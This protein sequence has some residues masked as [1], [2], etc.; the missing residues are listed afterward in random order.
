[1]TEIASVHRRFCAY[2][3]DVA[4]LLIPTLL[5]V[6]SLG[7]FPLILHLSYMCIN[8]GYFTYFISSTAQATPGQ[9]LMN[10][11][12]ITLDSSKIGL[13]LAFDRT[14]SQFFLPMLNNSIITFI[15]LFQ[16][17]VNALS[18]LEVIIVMLTFSWY[19][20][21]CFSQRKQ[22]FHDVLFDT[23]VVRKIN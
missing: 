5:I 10:I 18:T 4:I 19:L 3:I 22:A 17:S 1:M 11:Y 9:Q 16:T 15:K 23:I 13:S 8:C 14:I 6:L 12:T 2:L 7:D 20:V 21:A